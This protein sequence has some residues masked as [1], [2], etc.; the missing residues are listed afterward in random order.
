MALG[1]F[2]KDAFSGAGNGLLTGV[3]KVIGNFVEDPTKKAELNQQLQELVAK[4]QEAMATLAAQEYEAQLKDADSA[5]QM[6]I[7]ALKQESWFAKNQIHLLAISVTAGFFGLLAYMV[8]FDVPAANKDILN[9]ML[10]S[11]G[12]AWVSIVGFYF[13]SSKGSDDK[14]KIIDKLAS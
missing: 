9:I 14:N 1:D 4:H 8:K 11:L 3:S 6:Q 2:I 12:T 13:G 7:A 5:R 10:G